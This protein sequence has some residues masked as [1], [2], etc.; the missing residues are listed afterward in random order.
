MKILYFF[1]LLWVIFA[2]L[3]PDPATQINADP[4]GSG[5]GSETLSKSIQILRIRIQMRTRFRNTGTFTS[6]LVLLPGS[7]SGS[8][9]VWLPG[10]GSGSALRK[11]LD[12][13]PH[14]NQCES[15]TLPNTKPKNKFFSLAHFLIFCSSWLCL[16]TPPLALVT[17]CPRSLR[18]FPAHKKN[19][20]EDRLLTRVNCTVHYRLGY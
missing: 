9:L 18:H 5:Y 4:C 2:L 13:D 1:L 6:E 19:S 8:A 15:T 3:D 10:S 7:G 14:W 20:D 17:L 16:V 12:P 11:K